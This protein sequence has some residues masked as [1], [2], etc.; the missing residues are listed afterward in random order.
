MSVVKPSA[1]RPLDG[2]LWSRL[3]G[4]GAIVGEFVLRGTGKLLSVT[5]AGTALAVTLAPAAATDA[6][7][8]EAWLGTAHVAETI[9]VTVIT[10]TITII[11]AVPVPDTNP[12][13]DEG[14]ELALE[15]GV[16]DLLE[17]GPVPG[18]ELA[19]ASLHVAGDVEH[20]HPA[21]LRPRPRCQCWRVSDARL[22]PG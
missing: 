1:R 2:L 8:G 16:D 17:L 12:L 6:A 19:D 10:I 9:K 22:T 11:G 7:T 13:D 21:S 5:P 20:G 15:L 18:D 4:F 14:V 3:D